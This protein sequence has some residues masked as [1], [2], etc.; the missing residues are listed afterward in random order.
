MP[1]SC[2]AV[3]AG[4]I[5]DPPERSVHVGAAHVPTPSPMK[6]VD[7]GPAAVSVTVSC[8]PDSVTVNGCESLPPTSTVPVNISTVG[9]TTTDGAVDEVPPDPLSQPAAAD[10]R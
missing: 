6:I 9:L 8:P 1:L 2:A 7:G 4:T 3:P 10:T 5:V